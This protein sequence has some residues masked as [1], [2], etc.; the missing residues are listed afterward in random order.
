MN[1][2]CCL[3][4]EILK[5]IHSCHNEVDR[6]FFFF[7]ITVLSYVNI[8]YCTFILGEF[9]LK[10]VLLAYYYYYYY[11]FYLSAYT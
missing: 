10:I 5:D 4:N 6:V 3:Q 7:V 9:C 11:Y 1:C 2:H 8:C